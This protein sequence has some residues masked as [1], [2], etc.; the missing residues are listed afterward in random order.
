MR[1]YY[2]RACNFCYGETARN[3]ISNKKALPLNSR[4]NIA[5][6]Q[7]EI[8]QRKQNQVVESKVCSIKEIKK[9]D[10]EILLEIEKDIKNI[11]LERKSILGLKF[12]KPQII[13]VLNITPDSFSDGGLFF[14]ETKAYEQA[15]L[16]VDSGATIIDMAG[17]RLDRDRK[18]LMKK[19]S[20]KE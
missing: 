8:F 12:D 14:E 17:N 5:F 1:K 6:D 20:G 7:I 2:T 4:Q 15:K 11:T 18:P 10:K 13:G 16:M 3:L 9:L 19:K